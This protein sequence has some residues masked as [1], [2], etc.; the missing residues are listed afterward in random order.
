MDEKSVGGNVGKRKTV[1]ST[2]SGAPQGP[3]PLVEAPTGRRAPRATRRH[4][5]HGLERGDGAVPEGPVLSD[6]TR[7]MHVSSLLQAGAAEA[8]IDAGLPPANIHE[9]VVPGC[10]QSVFGI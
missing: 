2:I 10:V 7:R 8:M 6:P 5:P 4:R 1:V 9:E 3:A